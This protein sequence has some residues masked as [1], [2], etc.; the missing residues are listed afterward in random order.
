MTSPIPNQ[1]DSM[2]HI[3][4][5]PGHVQLIARLQ[6]LGEH[7]AGER[8]RAETVLRYIM[9]QAQRVDA[10]IAAILQRGY[11]IDAQ[12][13]RVTIDAEAGT[14]TAVSPAPAPTEPVAQAVDPVDIE[15]ATIREAVGEP[16]PL[17]HAASNRPRR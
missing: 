14:I 2:T 3:T 13:A 6:H 15:P 8:A 10:E 7:F 1:G 11:G 16:I 5:Q 4:M 9:E 12:H 17:P